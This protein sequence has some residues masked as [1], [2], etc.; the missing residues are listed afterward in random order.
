MRLCSWPG[1]VEVACGKLGLCLWG[2]NLGSYCGRKGDVCLSTALLSF[3]L[4]GPPFRKVVHLCC[5]P[6]ECRVP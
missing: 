6:Y 1:A 4:M 2:T 3:S 5:R